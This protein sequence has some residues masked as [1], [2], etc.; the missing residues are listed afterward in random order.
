MICFDQYFLIKKLFNSANKST[1]GACNEEKGS[2]CSVTVSFRSLSIFTSGAVFA[3]S[4]NWVEVAKLTGG[5]G[6]GTTDH[7]TCDHVDW[8]IRWEIEPTNSSER[9]A[10]LSKFFRIQ[11]LFGV[12][13]GLSPSSIT[14]LRKQAESCT[15]IIIVARLTWMFWQA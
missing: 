6:I 3:L 9:T 15:S 11:M 4:G 1:V 13:H 7:F 5:G 8:R 12:R 14:E 2:S 10:F